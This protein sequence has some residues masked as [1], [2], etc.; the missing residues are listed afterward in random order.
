MRPQTRLLSPLTV[1]VGVLLVGCA[2]SDGAHWSRV[3]DLDAEVD[4]AVTDAREEGKSE[5]SAKD[6]ASDVAMDVK[7]SSSQDATNKDSQA[8]GAPDAPSPPPVEFSFVAFADNQFATE[9]CTSGVPERLAIPKAIVK[10]APTFVIEAGDL[11]DH[12]YDPGA[13]A[14]LVSCYDA[15]VTQIP[16]FPSPGNHDC[17]SAGIAAFRTFL[18][19]QLFTRNKAV[20]GANYDKAFTIAYE[21]DTNTYSTNPSA[22]GS[23][24]NVPSGFSFK[25]YYAFKHKNAYFLSFEQGTRWWS[26]TP[27]QWVEKHL[28]AARADPAIEHLFVYMHHPMYSST[29]AEGGTGEA[30]QPV[31]SYYEALFKKYDVTMVFSG[32]AHV[33][34]RFYVSD[35]GTPTRSTPP[36]TSYPHDGKAV[37]YIVT[38]GGGGPLPSG[39]NPAPG[40]K[41]ELSY[42]FGPARG[43]GYHVTKVSVKGGS[44]KVEVVGV[45]GSETAF[46]TKV[47]DTFTI[48]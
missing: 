18:E 21:D 12:G 28:K 4:A 37:H 3:F 16:Y 32:H 31:R 30:I 45:D 9:S 14:K 8:D 17:G 27:R 33:Y 36:K 41:K 47:W 6:V 23:T 42:D 19:T 13:Y 11:M 29:M 38:G 20:W 40:E 24:T 44:L 46:T 5:A 43:C 7:D 34:D 48:Q 22:P 2:S 25:T 1:T 26:N 35:D 15:M 10:L 39:C